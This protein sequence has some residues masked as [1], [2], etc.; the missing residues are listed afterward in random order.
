MRK[1][2]KKVLAFVLCAAMVLT[3]AGLS[4]VL[5]ADTQKPESTSQAATDKYVYA[6]AGEATFVPSGYT[7]VY[8][9]ENG[10][11]YTREAPCDM[12]VSTRVLTTD[13]AEA[14]ATLE[15]GQEGFMT[16]ADGSV[17]QCREFDAAEASAY[18]DAVKEI[19]GG[20]EIK[21]GQKVS[22]LSQAYANT[23][24]VKVMI[25][26]ESDSVLD[27]DAMQVQLGEPLG[28][29]ELNAMRSIEAE[30]K[31]LT[32]TISAKLGYDIQVSDQFSLLTNA[33]SATVKYGDLAAINQM[34]GVKKAFLMP[35][36]AVPEIDANTVEAA[37]DIVPNLKYAGPAMGA[38]GPGIWAIRARACLLRSSTPAF[39]MKTLRLTRNRRI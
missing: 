3:A 12:Y 32:K 5:A 31:A 19:L 28:T 25:T 7:Y 36:F 11:V 39:A 35:K 26:F 33:V 29:A 34:A 9:G 8:T 1:A 27:M 21:E 38:N 20:A 18:S 2:F 10:Q 6:K 16:G 4:Q 37:A 24:Q 30:Q 23:D 22:V 15:Y 17:L 14:L 13:E